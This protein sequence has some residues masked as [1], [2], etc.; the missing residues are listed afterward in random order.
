ME[1]Y[2]K[3]KENESKVSIEIMAGITTFFANVPYAQAPGMDLNAFFAF[4]LSDTFDTLGTFIET[5]RRSGIFTA[6]EQRALEDGKGFKSKM[7][8]ALF[9]DSIAII[10]KERVPYLGVGLFCRDLPENKKVRY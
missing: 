8:K 5:G 1:R 6:E 10:F 2:F 4:S 3:L 9:A 7:D